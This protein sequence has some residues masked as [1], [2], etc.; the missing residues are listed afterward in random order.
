MEKFSLYNS[1]AILLPGSLPVFVLEI[2]IKNSGNESLVT[3]SGFIDVAMLIT[4]SV[5]CGVMIHILSF[6]MLTVYKKIG[7][8]TPICKI[9][10][11]S[12]YYAVMRDF[13]EE[14]CKER[15]NFANDDEFC[16]DSNCDTFYD[17]MYYT[18][19]VEDKIAVSKSFQ[20]F[21]YFFRNFFTMALLIQMLIFVYNVFYGCL[22]KQNI[23]I[24]SMLF[25]LFFSWYAAVW[26]RKNMVRKVFWTYYVLRNN[27]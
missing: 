27:L 6:K 8:Y 16:M 25:I 13:F 20:S 21:Y 5:F 10:K 1:L 19:E 26:Y 24:Y 23:I 11:R 22:V 15:F 18:L 17:W 7:I 2:L 3:G 14:K 4:A 9:F 12:E